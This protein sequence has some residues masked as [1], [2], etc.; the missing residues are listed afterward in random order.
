[1]YSDRSLSAVFA[2]AEILAEKL[3]KNISYYNCVICVLTESAGT[4]NLP[5][6]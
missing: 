1:M 5:H 3:R 4:T 6:K 2:G